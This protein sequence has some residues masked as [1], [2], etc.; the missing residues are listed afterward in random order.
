MIFLDYGNL[1]DF[2]SLRTHGTFLLPRLKRSF[3]IF[4]AAE[5]IKFPPLSRSKISREVDSC[6]IFGLWEPAQW[7]EYC[8]ICFLHNEEIENEASI[9]DVPWIHNFRPN[10]LSWILLCRWVKAEHNK[11]ASQKEAVRQEESLNT[12]H[13]ICR[14]NQERMVG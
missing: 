8:S 10:L 12:A 6:A 5:H 14:E 3:F 9:T 2:L 1:G 7:S 4:T 11:L 13:N